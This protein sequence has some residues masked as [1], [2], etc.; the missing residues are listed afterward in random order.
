MEPL[1]GLVRSFSPTS[2]QDA[3]KRALLL[4]NTLGTHAP[5]KPTWTP[6]KYKQ[7]ESSNQWKKE[8]SVMRQP[9][10]VFSKPSFPT[11]NSRKM[12][13]TTRNELRRKNLCFSCRKPWEPGH[14]CLGKGEVHYIEVVSASESENEKEYTIS[15]DSQEEFHDMREHG[16]VSSHEVPPT[17]SSLA[18]LN[19]APQFFT[20]KVLGKVLNEDVVVLIDGGAT[21]NFVNESFVQKKNIKTTNF[22][23]FNVATGKG[24]ISPCS[25]VVKQT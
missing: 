18:T 5:S 15:E 16:E 3:I 1:K 22:A 19:S 23:G 6:N 17:S 25:R 11:P 2:L 10:S 9:T 4:E 8:K 12:D 20:I 13:E 14:R 24:E 7:G 21:H